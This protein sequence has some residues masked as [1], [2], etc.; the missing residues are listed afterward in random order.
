MIQRNVSNKKYSD[1]KSLCISFLI[2]ISGFGHCSWKLSELKSNDVKRK[3]V[4]LDPKVP[5]QTLTVSIKYY[6]V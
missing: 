2:G 6:K 4:M 1:A 5:S 3:I